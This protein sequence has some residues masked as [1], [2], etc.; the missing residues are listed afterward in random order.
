[1]DSLTKEIID[2]YYMQERNNKKSKLVDIFKHP[3][4][5]GIT[6]LEIIKD[7]AI[8]G[9]EIEFIKGS[10]K[11][12]IKIG[13]D[14]FKLEEYSYY[15]LRKTALLQ[16]LEDKKIGLLKFKNEIEK[17]KLSSYNK[18]GQKVF[19]NKDIVEKIFESYLNKKSLSTIAEQLNTNNVQTKRGG[20]WYKSTVKYILENKEYVIN[21]YVSETQFNTVQEL[22][23][24]KYKK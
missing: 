9:Y 12:K 21:G 14:G 2:Y 1:M 18:A 20:K 13:I 22:L 19:D 24:S 7:L 4:I 10:S 3:E 23:K 6:Y 11:Y 5:K 16:E 8:S 15:R 17:L